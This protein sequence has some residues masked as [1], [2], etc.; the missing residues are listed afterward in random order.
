MDEP[1]ASRRTFLSLTAAA[2]GLVAAPMLL[3]AC[4]TTV[5]TSTTGTA[6]GASTTG[7]LR[8]GWVSEPDLLNP[9]TFSSSAAGEVLML[10][11]DNLLVYDAQLKP[12][13]GLATS[14]TYSPDGKDITYKLRSGV[15]WHDGQP[16]TA[17]DVKFTWDTI[18]KNN[19]GEAAQYLPDLTSVDIVD[20]S[21]VVAHFKRPQAFDPALIIPIVPKHIWGTMNSAAIQK[22]PND[23]PV[24]TGPY[25]FGTWKKGQSLEVERYA[26]WWGT[27][28][29]AAKVT[30]VHFDSADVMTQ[31]LVS[32][33]VDVLTEVPPTLWDGLRSQSSVTPVEL[34]SYSFHHIGMNVSPS[35]K[36]GGN[37]LLKD[38]VVRQ[39]LS[40]SLDRSQ[41]VALA[42]AGH[43]IPGSVLLPSAFG[44][45]QASIPAGQ[46]LDADPARAESMLDAAGY[47]KGSDGIRVS[48][49]GKPLSFRLIA[50]QATDV[51]VRAAQLF[52]SAAKAVGIKLSLQT[53]D[54]TTLGN[55]VYNSDA[56]N[57][58]LFVWG[59]DSSTPDA[60][61]L[62]GVPLTSQIGNN[63]DVYYSN[64]TYDALY[65]KQATTLDETK[66]RDLV[67]QMQLMYYEDAAYIVMWYQSKLQAYRK[68]GWKGWVEIPGGM[69][70]NFTRSNYL[71]VKPVG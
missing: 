58:D 4:S 45:W 20:A 2:A 54:E 12:S 44:D 28:P 39:A 65:E 41:L 27:Q 9:F 40:L 53:L 11:Y 17:E 29:A 61:Y 33:E 35:P 34:K 30:W 51:D 15:T 62:L 59:W 14:W 37:P 16:F 57:W 25:T 60:D 38:K 70:F 8:V 21:T 50:I 67:D 52:V 69:V 31:S 47:R 18:A 42:L 6:S 49:N 63:N 71:S 46:Q 10:I 22:Y 68:N 24:G 66:R 64:P 19:L 43:G 55:I 48:P 56:P 32:G 3:D 23:K 36:S 7:V 26:S 1:V 13:A 5:K